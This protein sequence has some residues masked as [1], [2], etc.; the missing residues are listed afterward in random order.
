MS[1]LYVILFPKQKLGELTI[2]DDSTILVH[3]GQGHQFT[4]GRNELFENKTF[5]DVRGMF[6]SGL[7]DT[8][9]VNT[10]KSA[11]AQSEEQVA[12]EE[13]IDVPEAFDWRDEYPQCVQEVLSIGAG[14]NCSSSYAIAS[15]SSV[16]DR[17]C[18]G[19]NNTVR[20]SAQEIID[21]DT[22]N[23]GCDGGYVN[24]V[25]NFGMKK[26]FVTEDCHEYKAKSKECEIDHFESNQC[27]IENHFYRLQ[28]FCITY[29]EENIKRELVKNGPVVAQM[30]AFTDFLAYRDG[31]YHKTNEAMKFNGQHVVK[32]I[33]YSK[34]MD[35]S[36]EWIVE[37]SW[38][39]D[40][41]TDGY[42][43][44]AGGRGDTGIDLFGMG[45]SV[46]PYTMYDY[47]S[48]QNMA[49]A[50]N[51]VDIDD[52]TGANVIDED[53]IIEEVV[54]EE[55]VDDSVQNLAMETADED[56]TTEEL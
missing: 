21:C 55:S 35:G 16:A 34:S 49:N 26:G 13:Q 19:S 4:H 31:T 14:M 11:K 20:L 29:Q 39:S 15:L 32:I 53:E 18:M 38:G 25:F 56:V 51:N 46:N 43:K 1:V 7:S 3:N 2:I 27:R 5:G 24:K 47:D 54:E 23:N 6:F 40:W 42:V 30:T 48:M 28:D 41:G 44:I 37:N 12:D 22:A 17:I 8:N 10:C 9:S 50:A 36:T 52:L 45:P 33:G